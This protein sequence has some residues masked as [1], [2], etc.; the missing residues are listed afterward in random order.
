MR[1]VVK[2]VARIAVVGASVSAVLTL[3][4]VV[5]YGWL[6]LCVESHPA[7]AGVC[8][9]GLPDWLFLWR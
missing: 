4:A 2:M 9:Q 7:N 1:S 8:L 5:L 3:A 6:D